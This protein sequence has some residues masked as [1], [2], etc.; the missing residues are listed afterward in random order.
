MIQYSF[1]VKNLWY[2]RHNYTETNK[3]FENF[4]FIG[5]VLFRLS[6]DIY[7]ALYRIKYTG[8]NLPLRNTLSII[9]KYYVYFYLFLPLIKQITTVK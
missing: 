5:K 1:F 4:T 9:Y 8:I 2:L 7:I 3:S 6:R